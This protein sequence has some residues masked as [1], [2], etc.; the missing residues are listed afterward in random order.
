MEKETIENKLIYI[1]ILLEKINKNIEKYELI[2]KEN[3]NKE[4]FFVAIS[5]YIEELIETSIKINNLILSEHGD[6]AQ[7]YYISFIKLLKYYKNLNEKEIKYFAKLTSIRNKI[8]HEYFN[9]LDDMDTN[10][11]IY[12]KIIKE[13][14]KYIKIIKKIIN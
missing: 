6:F 10:I 8:A 12:K 7:T 13:F 1:K 4:I 14:P 11:K 5:K 3:E 9:F 2:E